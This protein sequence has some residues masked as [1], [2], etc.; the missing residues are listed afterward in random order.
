MLSVE[1]SLSRFRPRWTAGLQ[2]SSSSQHDIWAQQ[3]ARAVTATS[4]KQSR[5][6][7][8]QDDTKWMW[9]LS[10]LNRNHHKCDGCG[11]MMSDLQCPA[12]IS[13]F[14]YY[15]NKRRLFHSQGTTCFLSFFLLVH[16]YSF[17][18]PFALFLL[19]PFT[20]ASTNIVSYLVVFK[21]VVF[22]HVL[23]DLSGS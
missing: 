6:L 14:I 1:S 11:G 9:A 3:I 8:K 22:N 23:K 17:W 18:A 5:K 12:W 13:S 21:Y 2:S 16:H 20:L 7:S 19:R 10:H 15:E 4:S